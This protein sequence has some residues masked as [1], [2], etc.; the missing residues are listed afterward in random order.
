MIISEPIVETF[1]GNR[2][3]SIMFGTDLSLLPLSLPRS[4]SSI[5]SVLPSPI[6]FIFFSEV[7]NLEIGWYAVSPESS[8]TLCM[9]LINSSTTSGV[10][11]DSW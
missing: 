8:T 1:A 10:F 4:A 6:L 5:D 11:A 7:P 2:I 3:P 9:P